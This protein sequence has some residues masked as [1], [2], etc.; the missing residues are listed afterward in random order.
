VIFTTLDFFAGDG[1]LVG[2]GSGSFMAIP[3][4]QWT[5]PPLDDVLERFREPRGALTVPLAERIGCER[6]EVGTAVLPCAPAVH[7]AARAINGGML[8]VA[9]EEAALSADPEAR[10]IESM[11][12]RYL[13]SIRVGP[14]VARADVHH[15]TGRVEVH[16]AAT[17][18]IA[19]IA[20]TRSRAG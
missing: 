13:R 4:P 10:W 1:R 16:D 7:N 15:G 20:T 11:H 19:A 12:L 9:V 18:A 6:T 14:A 17:D 3:D 5:A 2:F 8:A